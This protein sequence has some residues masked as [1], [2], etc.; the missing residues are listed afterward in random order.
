M[1]VTHDDGPEQAAWL[2]RKV[3]GSGSCATRRSVADLGAPVLVV[4][5]FTLYGDARKGR[6][7]TWQDAAP[8]PV[9]EPLYEAVC[10]ELASLGVPRGEGGV[11]RGHGRCP[12]STT[13][14]SRSGWRPRGR[15]ERGGPSPMP[16]AWDLCPPTGT[17]PRPKDR[18]GAS[19]LSAHSPSSLDP[20][21]R[22][23]R[24]RAGSGDAGHGAGDAAVR[25]QRPHL[26][27]DRLRLGVGGRLRQQPLPERSGGDPEG[28]LLRPA[29]HRRRAARNGSSTRCTSTSPRRSS[30]AKIKAQV[31]PDTVLLKVQVDR[32]RPEDG[33]GDQQ[34]GRHDPPRPDR[35]D[36][37]RPRQEDRE[38]QGDRR[39]PG[40][41]ADQ[42]GLPQRRSATSSSA[43]SSACCSASRSRSSASCSTPR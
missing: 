37:D 21:R 36:R 33:A 39:R 1:G 38:P 3:A 22:L 15:R 29:G 28:H 4:S 13:D 32:R 34:A 42:P 30:R 19:R 31:V 43:A 41:A 8:G 11:R 5:Q 25:L 7:P 27:L 10:T 35:G 14:R 20:D 12:S 40:H 17:I 23:H 9:A 16:Y 18:C 2:A 26:H 6:R 24:G